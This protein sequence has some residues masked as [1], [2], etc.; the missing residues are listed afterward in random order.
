MTL[1]DTVELDAYR[2]AVSAEAIAANKAAVTEMPVR[3]FSTPRATAVEMWYKHAGL[4]A[5][6]KI[7][8]ANRLVQDGRAVPSEAG[9]AVLRA[10][11]EQLTTILGLN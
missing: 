5:P 3:E 7:A 8:V 4:I 11:H 1:E 6:S 2:S 9:S 10:L